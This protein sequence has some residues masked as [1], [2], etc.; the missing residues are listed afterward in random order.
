MKG[1]KSYSLQYDRLDCFI[2]RL[3]HEQHRK[4]LGEP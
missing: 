2:N 1:K 3:Q 4:Q